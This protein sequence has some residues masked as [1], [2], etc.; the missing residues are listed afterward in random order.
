[1]T[2]RIQGDNSNASPAITGDDTDSGIVIGTNEVDIV[3]NGTSKVNIDTD[4]NVEIT[5]TGSLRVPV[6]TEAQR[7]GTGAAGMLRYNSDTNNLEYFRTD[8]NAFVPVTDTGP[9]TSIRYLVIAGG[10]GGGAAFQGGCAGGGGAGGYRTNFGTGNVSGG[11]SAVEADMAMVLDTAL[12]LTVGAGA[13]AQTGNTNS[14]DAANNGSDSTFRTITS[15]GGGGGGRNDGGSGA[16]GG[17]GGGAGGRLASASPGSGTANQGFIGGDCT[18]DNDLA[19]GGGGGAGEAGD[20]GITSGSPNL[21]QG[22]DGLASEI[23]GTSVT[24]GGG[25]GSGGNSS[26][27]TVDANQSGGLGGA[28]GGGGGAA[29]NSANGTDGTANTGGG[30]GGNLRSCSSSNGGAGGSGVIIL[31][32]PSTFNGNNLQATF[33]EGVVVNG[34]TVGV[35]GA[36]VAGDTTVAGQLIWTITAA[37]SDTVT[38]STT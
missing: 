14:T 17:S 22:G 36:V 34:T 35:G 16:N 33:T 24:R 23:T 11:A 9:D 37:A 31:R 27:C 38:F 1:M 6:G 32:T 28:G 30:G 5:S 10:G 12:D 3:T 29:A 18:V 25:G 7:P 15:T 13:A 21:A 2:V 8:S 19:A 26:S 4:G 20:Q